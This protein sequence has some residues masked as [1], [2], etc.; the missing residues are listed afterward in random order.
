MAIM[1][2]DTLMLAG[3]VPITAVCDYMRHEDLATTL[4]YIGKTAELGAATK[5]IGGVMGKA[6]GRKR[7]GKK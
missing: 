7:K 4:K 2:V 1:G 6:P 5:A 3:G